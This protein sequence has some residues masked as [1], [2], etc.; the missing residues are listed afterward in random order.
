M[1]KLISFSFKICVY[2]FFVV[3][4]HAE[5][6]KLSEWSKE[7]HSKCGIRASVSRVRIPHFPQKIIKTV[8]PS[9]LE[10]AVFIFFCKD[11]IGRLRGL[12]RNPPLLGFIYLLTLCVYLERGRELIAAQVV[13]TSCL[14]C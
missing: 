4:L 5:I 13:E 2:A 3:P 12:R 10:Q 6:G 11:A 9:S 8:C 14:S 7:P 1:I